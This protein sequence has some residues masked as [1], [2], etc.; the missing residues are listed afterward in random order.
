M[1]G[2]SSP[3]NSKPQQRRTSKSKEKEKSE[4]T[5]LENMEDNIVVHESLARCTSE[6]LGYLPRENKKED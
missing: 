5:G 3:T 2:Q 1:A 4:I 6:F